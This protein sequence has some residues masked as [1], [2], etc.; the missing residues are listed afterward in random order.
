MDQQ[1]ARNIAS[2]AVAVAAVIAVTRQCRKPAS[3]PGRL[4]LWTMNRSHTGV[5][6]WGLGHVAVEGDYTI[7]DVGCG[8]GATVR[9]LAGL[10]TNGKVYGIDYSKES[11]AVS[12]RANADLMAAGRVDIRQGTVSHL[13][14]ADAT[15]DLVTAVETHYY[16]PSPVEDMREI[17]R[18]LKP[19]GRLVVI[20]ETYKGRRF[21]WLYQPAMKLLSATYLTVA[22][23]ENLLTTAGYADVQ[24][25]EDHNRGWICCVGTRRAEPGA[26]VRDHIQGS[27]AD[28]P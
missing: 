23:H 26:P 13:P 22:E 8:G 19:G 5:T 10:A 3:L 4:F 20:A 1:V 27:S 21:D 14:Y 11:V 9:A 15:F 17:L 12:R 2:S 18:V 6:R 24:A 28:G 16:W 7:L 25:H